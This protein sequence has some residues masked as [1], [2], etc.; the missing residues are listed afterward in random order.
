MDAQRKSNN[1]NRHAFLRKQIHVYE[2]VYHSQ[3]IVR[4]FLFIGVIVFAPRNIDRCGWSRKSGVC[5]GVLEDLGMVG[6]CPIPYGHFIFLIRQ[7]LLTGTL[8]V[9][10]R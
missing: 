9:L 5:L 10:K 2:I 8:L 1:K 7:A 4:V 3:I 6:P